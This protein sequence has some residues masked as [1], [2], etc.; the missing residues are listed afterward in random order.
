MLARDHG[1]YLVVISRPDAVTVL[2]GNAGRPTG[3]QATS[4]PTTQQF[5]F[6]RYEC[7]CFANNA[8]H[9]CARAAG[10][11]NGGRRDGRLS[12]G[13]GARNRAFGCGGS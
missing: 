10:T 3:S 12:D 9:P 5:R 4:G 6:R 1:S 13:T 11:G 2:A 8:P 7:S